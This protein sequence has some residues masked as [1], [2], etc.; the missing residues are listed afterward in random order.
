MK[1]SFS[2]RRFLRNVGGFVGTTSAGA[3]F[4]NIVTADE[5]RSATRGGSARRSLL[6]VI[7]SLKNY[8]NDFRLC[9]LSAAVEATNSRHSTPAHILVN[10]DDPELL[11]AFFQNS[12]GLPF[13]QVFAQENILSFRFGSRDFYIENVT[14]GVFTDRIAQI[15]RLGITDGTLV[16]DYAHQYL[17]YNP[18][19]KVLNDP[20]H[21]V[22]SGKVHLRSVRNTSSPTIEFA[23]VIRGMIDS[24]RLNIIPDLKL[25]AEWSK[26]LNSNDTE[27]AKDVAST[28]LTHFSAL[29]NQ[30]PAQQL[31]ELLCSKLVSTSLLGIFKIDSKK[32]IQYFQGLAENHSRRISIRSLWIAALL[33]SCSGSNTR[34][35]VQ[36]AYR[37][38]H[39][40]TARRTA[41]KDLR[42]AHALLR[43][44]S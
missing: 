16:A 17:T 15:N 11:N 38:T 18:S 34:H 3:L 20:Y 7:Q 41:S 2:R 33:K 14:N 6:Q 42:H 25:K 37:L 44:R 12:H 30:L 43:S 39:D 27:P 32:V 1:P 21:A 4:P 31:S 40:L 5:I 9:G 36:D 26:L 19:S 28:L 10:A 35:A 29:A 8:S 23:S 22:S 13:N 24:A